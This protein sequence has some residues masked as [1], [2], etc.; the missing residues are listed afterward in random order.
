MIYSGTGCISQEF[1]M[2]LHAGRILLAALLAS[3]LCLTASDSQGQFFKK[4]QG[5]A[6]EKKP[7]A[8]PAPASA[9]LTSDAWQKVPMTPVQP[10]EID[11]LVSE[12]FAKLKMAPAPLTTDE[13]FIRRVSQQ[14]TG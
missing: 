13:Q 10:G 9:R 11:R 2:K 6:D 3:V 14:L 12:E 1:F 7:A 4:F 8:P 5:K